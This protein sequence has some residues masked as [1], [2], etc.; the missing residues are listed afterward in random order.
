MAVTVVDVTVVD[1]T[2]VDVTVVD[3][4]VVVVYR[5]PPP[6]AQHASTVDEGV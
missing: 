5:T 4:N 3:V 1:V 6:H 2:V